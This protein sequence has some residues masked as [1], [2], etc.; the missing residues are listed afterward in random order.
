MQWTVDGG[1]WTVVRK[2]TGQ[3]VVAGRWSLVGN[4]TTLQEWNYLL[5]RLLATVYRPRST[6]LTFPQRLA[7]PVR[8]D[9]VGRLVDL[10]GR[11]D[12]ARALAIEAILGEADGHDSDRLNGGAKGD[13]ILDALAQHLA[14]VGAWAGDNLAM[15]IDTHTAEAPDLLAHI[16]HLLFAE[17]HSAP[18][19]IRGVDADIHRGEALAL[20]ALPVVVAQVG[21]RNEVAV[22]KRE[23]VVVIFKVER[24]AETLGHLGEEAERA[25]IVAGAQPVKKRLSKLQAEVGVGVFLDQ[26]HAQLAGGGA[27]M[28]LDLLLGDGEAV[29]DHIAQAL[30]AN[31][32]EQVAGLEAEGVGDTTGGDSGDHA[33]LASDLFEVGLIF[34]R[35]R[36]PRQA[37]GRR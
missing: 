22:E 6:V 8:I 28:E 27:H 2:L 21:K 5:G 9:P 15:H 33:A 16:G 10:D 26:E 24:L 1:R 12:A 3:T 13:Q 36:P 25:F 34:H 11:L 17:H 32:D 29:V 30:L 31:G 19:G 23:P 7:L 4:I 37:G 18:E 14:I 20:D 35:L